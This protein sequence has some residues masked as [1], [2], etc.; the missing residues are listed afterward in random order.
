VS[1]GLAVAVGVAA[2]ALFG[3]PRRWHPL[4][5]FG[6][7]AQ[8]VEERYNHGRRRAR[9]GALAVAAL[10]GLPAAAAALLENLPGPQWLLAGLVIYLALGARSLAEHARAVAAPL[11]DGDLAGARAAVGRLVSR[12]PAELDAPGVARAGIESVLENG[13]DAVFGALFWFVVAGLPGL[14][15]YRLSNTLDAMWGYRTARFADF[16]RTAARLDDVLNWPVARLTAVTYALAGRTG[17][18]LRCWRTQAKAWKS[19]NAGVVMAAGAGALGIRL[20]GPARYHGTT[21]ER[22]LLGA[23]VEPG[24]ADLQRAVALVRRGLAGWLTVIILGDWLVV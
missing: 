2:D 8:R 10:V 11:A 12:D 7:L 1:A 24:A 14:V 13:A 9:H 16:G 15:A 20:G 19:P 21:E 23:G 17:E 6:R 22:P 5:A 4:A 3:E 18:A